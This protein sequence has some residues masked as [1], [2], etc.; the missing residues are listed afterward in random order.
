MEWKGDPI[1]TKNGRVRAPKEVALGIIEGDGIGPE[2]M[3]VA[4]EVV[5]RAVEKAYEDRSVVWVE[6]LAGKKA[7][8]EKGTLLPKETI[9]GIRELKAA[10]KG[11]LETP[12]G[13]GHRSLNVTL[14]TALDLYANVRPVQ[15]YGA[16]T[17][18]SRAEEVDFIIFRENTEDVYAGIEWRAGT[19][20]AKKFRNFLLEEFGIEVR[21]DAGIGVKPIS[22][23]GSKRIMRRAIQWAVEKGRKRVTIMHK[24]NIMKF[25]EGAF[26]EW[27]YQVAREEFGEYVSIGERRPG[28][29][30]VDDRIADN[31][32]Q[33]IILRPGEYDVIVTPNLNGDYIS[34]AAAALVG[35]VG[36]AA[37]LNLGDEV[38]LA[39]PVHGTAPDIAGKG[40]ANPS[41]AILSGALLL[42]YIGWKKAAMLIREAIKRAITSG[43]KTL[44]LGGNLSTEGFGRAVMEEME[45]VH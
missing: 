33:Q 11:P 36:M 5:N 45:N 3:G 39:E 34:D 32:F 40:I 42:E 13:S 30:L 10:L 4:K 19:E 8:R 17:P 28:R 6:L 27:A 7:L 31:M 44:D 9:E 37:G 22:E 38:A 25:T 23:F 1:E 21:E 12:V 43:R 35:G 29:I 24:G 2:V 14:R 26:R 16:P 41:A 18:F 15:Y 20:E